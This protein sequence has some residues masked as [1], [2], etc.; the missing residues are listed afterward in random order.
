MIHKEYLETTYANSF[1]NGPQVLT[2][3]TLEFGK[4]FRKLFIF[5]NHH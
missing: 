3:E 1:E 2:V 5:A 4:L